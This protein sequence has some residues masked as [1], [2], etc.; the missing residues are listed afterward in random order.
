MY[1]FFVKKSDFESCQ[2]QSNVVRTERRDRLML[3]LLIICFHPSVPDSNS[4]ELLLKI[5]LESFFTTAGLAQS[6]ARLI[7][8]KT[9]CFFAYSNTRGQSNKMSGTRLKT[10]SRL[11][12]P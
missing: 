9:V 4:Q 2:Q 8:C 5:S 1:S 10:V 3:Q 7:D 6:V 12:R 11:T